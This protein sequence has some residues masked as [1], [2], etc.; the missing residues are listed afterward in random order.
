VLRRSQVRSALKD[1]LGHAVLRRRVLDDISAAVADV[2]ASEKKMGAAIRGLLKSTDLRMNGLAHCSDLPVSAPPRVGG[3]K[4]VPTAHLSEPVEIDYHKGE[5][6]LDMARPEW[7]WTLVLF[8]RRVQVVNK[9]GGV[10]RPLGELDLRS[11]C[12]LINWEHPIR[13]QMD[14]RGFLRMAL[15]WVLAKEA[16]CYAECCEA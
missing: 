11:G 14:E 7:D 2:I 8:D 15:S 13:T 12:L 6:R 3:L 16:P 4:T 1:V 5:I 9:R 10:N